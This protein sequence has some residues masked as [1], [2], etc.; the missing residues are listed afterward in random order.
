MQF[1]A[2]IWL[3]INLNLFL[4]KNLINGIFDVFKAIFCYF[5]GLYG[6]NK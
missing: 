4:R 3:E 2:H 6:K 1:P 5:L